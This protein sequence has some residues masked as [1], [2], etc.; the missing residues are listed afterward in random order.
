LEPAGIAGG[1]YLDPA[2]IGCA[3]YL[4]TARRWLS[5]TT[6]SVLH[7]PGASASVGDG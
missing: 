1:P 4:E 6:R 7:T 5:D 2:E 3:D